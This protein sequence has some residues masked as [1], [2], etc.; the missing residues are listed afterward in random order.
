MNEFEI[1]NLL[2]SG[3]N[4]VIVYK[5]NFILDTFHGQNYYI[6]N[7]KTKDNHIHVPRKLFLKLLNGGVIVRRGQ[8][9]CW[10]L[11]KEL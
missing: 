3:P 2:R 5:F 8:Y 7:S 11:N 4:M 6:I 10:Y 9:N 1:L